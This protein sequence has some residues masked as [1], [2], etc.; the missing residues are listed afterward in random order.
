MLFH[1]FNF[2]I[3][4]LTAICFLDNGNTTYYEYLYGEKPSKIEE[5]VITVEEDIKVLNFVFIY[6]S[7]VQQI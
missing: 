3:L 6:S 5:P 4:F 1:S 7:Q 2:S